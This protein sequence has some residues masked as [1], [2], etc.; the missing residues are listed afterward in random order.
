MAAIKCLIVDDESLARDLI[1]LHLQ[2]FDG[3]EIVGKCDS[4]IEAMA[5]L[6]E[7][8][9]DV[10]FLDI[11][12]PDIT[13]LEFISGLPGQPMTVLTTA[14]S[15]YAVEAFELDVFDYLLKPISFK[16][17]FKTIQK[18]QARRQQGAE[19]PSTG[20]PSE[21]VSPIHVKSEGKLIQVRPDE[22][23]FVE[24]MQKYVKIY[25]PEKRIV[26][27]LSISKVE[28][29]LPF[30]NF[31]RVHKSYIINIDHLEELQGNEVKIGRS[32]IPVSRAHKKELLER[33]R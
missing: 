31:L 13:G 5:V 2:K 20:E 9:V 3:F 19:Q 8:S 23:L 6:N 11:E 10:I 14:Y 21:K 30:P 22:I 28:E 29:L 25:L 17:F 15:E 24:A 18:I 1:E 4:A 16:R 7:V 12:M 33:L 27:L 26:S 32:R